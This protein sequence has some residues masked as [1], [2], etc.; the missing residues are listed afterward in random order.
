M[1]FRDRV[2][3]FKIPRYD[4]R[5]R[6]AAAGVAVKTALLYQS[7]TVLT[8][9]G[10]PQHTLPSA[11]SPNPTLVQVQCSFTSTETTTEGKLYTYTQTFTQLLSSG[12]EKKGGGVGGRRGEIR[13]I[14][15]RVMLTN[16]R[17]LASPS[18]VSDIIHQDKYTIHGLNMSES[19][20]PIKW[21]RG[22]TTQTQKHR[23]TN[24]TKQQKGLCGFN[25]LALLGH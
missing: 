3:C 1:P 23:D 10:K 7:K 9:V 8:G 16:P 17:F 5:R 4:P 14:Y 20:Q 25:A 6:N 19:F 18:R 21:K 15:S 11:L 12:E 24:T 22:K 13:V 2:A